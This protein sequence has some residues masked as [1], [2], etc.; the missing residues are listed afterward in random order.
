MPPDISPD[1]LSLA[2]S[3]LKVGE[4]EAVVTGTV[5]NS[6]EESVGDREAIANDLQRRWSRAQ[7]QLH[8]H[9]RSAGWEKL[10]VRDVLARTGLDKRG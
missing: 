1:G 2:S 10:V 3:E 8:E 6:H 5:E 4:N 7:R 9:D